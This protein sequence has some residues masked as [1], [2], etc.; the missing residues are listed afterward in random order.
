MMAANRF[1]AI[2]AG[3]TVPTCP[4]L[5]VQV[6]GISGPLCL[7]LSRT[8]RK[9][10]DLRVCRIWPA[11]LVAPVHLRKCGFDLSRTGQDKPAFSLV[12]LSGTGQDRFYPG[13]ERTV[14]LSL[15]IGEGT[16]PSPTKD[17][18]TKETNR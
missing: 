17:T 15:S 4:Q 6:R 1:R 18:T 11:E 10:S 7:H 2:G 13:S 14:P 16:G 8:G 5:F 12:R 9:R 3:Q